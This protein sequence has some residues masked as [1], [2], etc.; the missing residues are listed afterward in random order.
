[1]NLKPEV[2]G[3][4]F[5]NLLARQREMKLAQALEALRRGAVVLDVGVWTRVPDPH[6]SENWLEKQHVAHR[7]LIAVG[8]EDMTDFRAK[9]PDILCVQGDGAALPFCDGAVDI[10]IANAVLEHV[11][12]DQ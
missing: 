10:A 3:S 2:L 4:L 7:R 8:L 9:Y 5:D 12:Q 6:A 11:A 1:M